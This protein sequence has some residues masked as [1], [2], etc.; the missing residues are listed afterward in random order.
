MSENAAPIILKN[1]KKPKGF[2]KGKPAGPGR[3][4]GLLNKA[5][6]E[7]KAIATR[8]VQDPRY[9]ERLQNRIDRGEAGSVEVLLWH[10]AYGK[11]KE[12]VELTGQNN[13]PLRFTLNLGVDPS[14]GDD[15]STGP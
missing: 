13:G 8:I 14:R 10:Y 6:Q 7:V 4:K 2:Q 15:G 11:P 1:S 3:P 12:R 5:T 9:L